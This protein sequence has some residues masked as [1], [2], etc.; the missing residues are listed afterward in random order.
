MLYDF[1]EFE[2]PGGVVGSFAACLL[3]NRATPFP[4]TAKVP[5]TEDV[6]YDCTAPGG[7]PYS[8]RWTIRPAHV[9]PGPQA[10]SSPPQ[11][12]PMKYRKQATER[13]ALLSLRPTFPSK[14]RPV[15]VR[16]VLAWFRPASDEATGLLFRGGR[17]CAKA[18]GL[19]IFTHGRSAAGNA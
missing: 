17:F 10:N 3:S 12:Y 4:F 19:G 9:A 8:L 18:H 16:F 11:S 6:E 14:I 7:F 1:V 13:P 5:P 2:A 15:A